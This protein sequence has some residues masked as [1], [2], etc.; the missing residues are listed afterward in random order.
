MLIALLLRLLKAVAGPCKILIAGLPWGK[1]KEVDLRRLIIYIVGLIGLIGVVGIVL[2]VLFRGSEVPEALVT[3]T[4][5]V[6]TGLLGILIRS[7]GE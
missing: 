7:P 1:E 2:T 6:V 5:A 4:T 3:I